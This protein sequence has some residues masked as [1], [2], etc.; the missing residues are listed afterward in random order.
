[1]KIVESVVRMSRVSA[2]GGMCLRWQFITVQAITAE[3]HENNQLE[4]HTTL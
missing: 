2:L 1:M 4:W 3:R